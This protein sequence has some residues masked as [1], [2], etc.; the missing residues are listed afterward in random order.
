[1]PNAKPIT[2]NNRAVRTVPGFSNVI[3]TASNLRAYSVGNIVFVRG[4]VTF[5]AATTL[6]PRVSAYIVLP[7][8]ISTFI[9]HSSDSNQANEATQVTWNTSA[10][11]IILSG[12]HVPNSKAGMT[13]NF[14]GVYIK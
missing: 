3:T 7:T 4:T 14:S 5:S 6:I 10:R 8:S 12:N 11:R 1:M 9:G 13:I 2:W